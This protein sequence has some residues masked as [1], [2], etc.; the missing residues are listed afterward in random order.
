MLVWDLVLMVVFNVCLLLL[1]LSVDWFGALFWMF[2]VILL[3]SLVVSW[4]IL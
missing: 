3:C 4:F 2:V 1:Y